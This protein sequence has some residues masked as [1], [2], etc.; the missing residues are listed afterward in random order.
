VWTALV[1]PVA[2]GGIPPSL[3][4]VQLKMSF[5]EGGAFDFHSN[6]ERIKE[7]LQ[8]AVETS[9]AVDNSRA[10]AIST[11]QLFILM[12]SL[13]TMAL[14]TLPLSS[15]IPHN[16]PFHCPSQQYHLQ[17]KARRHHP[18]QAMSHPK[19]DSSHQWNHLRDMK[20]YN[21]RVWLTS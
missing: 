7:R 11:I 17:V 21:N 12:S 2:G 15:A 8:Q 5:K 6:F 4:A 3:P 20:K 1:Q 18:Q 19:T 10:G 16:L 13:L 9:Q 14:V